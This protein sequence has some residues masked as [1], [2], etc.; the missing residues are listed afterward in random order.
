[1]KIQT[2]LEFLMIAS[3]IGLLVLSS[4]I[5][6]G[7]MVKNYKAMSARLPPNYSIAYTPTYYQRPY[8]YASMPMLSVSGYSN[9]LAISAFGCSNGTIDVR[10]RSSSIDFS[11]YNI[12]QSFYNAIMYYDNFSHLSSLSAANLSYSIGCAGQYYNG[13]V[14]LSTAYQ[15]QTPQAQY[16]AYLSGRNESV[17]YSQYLQNIS[18]LM[19]PAHCTYE[20]FFYNPYP[21]SAQCGSSSAWQYRVF[22]SICSSNG[23]SLT[24]TY[25]VVP[26]PS[27]YQLVFASSQENYS[28]SANLTINVGYP[29]NSKISSKSLSSQIRFGSAVVGN[30]S[31][32]GINYSGTPPTGLISYNGLLVTPNSSYVSDYEQAS[33]SLF[34][35]L[36]FY[37]SSTVSPTIASEIA[38]EVYSYDYYSAKLLNA[39]KESQSPSSRCILSAN[40]IKCPATSPFY[41]YITANAS[42]YYVRSNQT[43]EYRGS[44]IKVYN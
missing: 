9:R 20:N 15:P 8:L 7:G 38:Q 3:A 11:Y 44:I 42:P 27:S 40:A 12:S 34:S 28:Y 18:Y 41:Y 6:Y 21:I 1:M 4:V 39:S 33:Q 16:S 29:L 14:E 26:E 17:T 37:N 25:C 43:L 24:Q 2:S 36:S 31:V 13:S 35:T 22:S 5:Q 32:E 23:G 19:Q 10:I 30:A